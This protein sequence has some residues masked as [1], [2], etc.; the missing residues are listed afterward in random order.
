MIAETS[1]L[2]SCILRVLQ[3]VQ[4]AVNIIYFHTMPVIKNHTC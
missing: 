3:A 4:Q 1:Q 2:E